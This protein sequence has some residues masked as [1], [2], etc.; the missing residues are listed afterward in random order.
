MG[1]YASRT[2]RTTGQAVEA[3]YDNPI[4]LVI[5]VAVFAAVLY[6]KVKKSDE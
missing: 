1:P 5:V 3:F 4:L 2:S 6:W